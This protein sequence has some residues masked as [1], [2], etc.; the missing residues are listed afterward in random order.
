MAATPCPSVCLVLDDHWGAIREEC[1][2]ERGHNGM[3]HVERSACM[4][5]ALLCWND[6]PDPA[7]EEAKE[8][9]P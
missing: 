4:P 1:D 7:S 5:K 2:G 6:E 9:G 8:E 3:H